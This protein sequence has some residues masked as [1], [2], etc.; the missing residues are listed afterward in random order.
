MNKWRKPPSAVLESGPGIESC[1]VRPSIWSTA[2]LWGATSP[3]LVSQLYLVLVFD[4]L[5]VCTILY[6][7]GQICCA[8]LWQV[9]S[10]SPNTFRA[11]PKSVIKKFGFSCFLMRPRSS[12]KLRLWSQS[13]S[14]QYYTLPT[15]TTLR[16]SGLSDVIPFGQCGTILSATDILEQSVI[17]HKLCTITPVQDLQTHVWVTWRTQH[18]TPI[19]DRRPS[20]G[21][22]RKKVSRGHTHK[23]LT[24]WAYS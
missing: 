20:W 5:L 1:I 15:N 3:W 24:K 13:I 14:M 23:T 7:A 10:S 4:G 2:F 21:W 19:Y 17:L 18:R 9:F 16:S 22:D 12:P 8:I 11:Y 6:M